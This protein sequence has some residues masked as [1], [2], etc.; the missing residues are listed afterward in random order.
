MDMDSNLIAFWRA[1]LSTLLAIVKLWE[2]WS[3]RRRIEVSYSF[4][5]ISEEGE[6]YYN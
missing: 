4:I 3:A 1:G 5:G 2:L 6:R